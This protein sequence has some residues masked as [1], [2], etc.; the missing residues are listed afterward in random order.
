[1]QV[2]ARN[3]LWTVGHTGTEVSLEVYDGYIRIIMR[4]DGTV[5]TLSHDTPGVESVRS[6]VLGSTLKSLDSRFGYAAL[7]LNRNVFVIRENTS[8]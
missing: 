8:L 5:F 2:A 1:M 4:D 3:P 6:V 7:G